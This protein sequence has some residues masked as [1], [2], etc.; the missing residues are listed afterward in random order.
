[1]KTLLGDLTF[2]IDCHVLLPI[3][4]VVV[5]LDTQSKG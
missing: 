1:M 3:G 2:E 5:P 4:T